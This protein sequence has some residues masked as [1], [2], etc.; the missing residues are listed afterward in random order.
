MYDAY[1]DAVRSG[2]PPAAAI[3]AVQASF[4]NEMAD[5]DEEAVGWLALARAQRQL[6]TVDADVRLRVQAI[7]EGGVGLERWREAGPDALRQRKAVLTRFSRD[8]ARPARPARRAAASRA[9]TP[10]VAPEPAPFEVGDCLAIECADG[11]VEA[12]VVTRRNVSP[13][14]TSH[15]LTVVNVPAGEAPAPPHFAPPRWRPVHPER[16]DL[17]VKVEVYDTGWPRQRKRYRVV[18]RIDPG[19]VPQPLTLRPATWAN[20]WRSFRRGTEGQVAFN[21]APVQLTRPIRAAARRALASAPS[22][23]AAR[24]MHRCR[25]TAAGIHRPA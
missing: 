6:G 15:I 11:R 5:P 23:R 4:A 17:A 2:Q 3:S 1:L 21:V 18:C 12:A 20:L 16:P 10:A 24:G 13:S 9:A 7:V 19:D 14:T 8:L 25:Q 22:T